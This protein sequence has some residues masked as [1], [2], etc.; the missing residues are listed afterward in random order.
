MALWTDLPRT[1]DKVVILGWAETTRNLAPWDDDYEIW[2]LNEA[3]QFS[4]IKRMDRL[5]QLHPRWDFS[6]SNNVNDPNHLH[7]LR[8]ESGKCAYC[9]GKGFIEI[10]EKG[11]DKEQ[12]AC[13]FCDGGIYTPKNRPDIPIYMQK[14]HADIPGSVAYPLKEVAD[15]LFPENRHPYFTSSFAYMAG[16]AYIMGYKEIH[17]YGFEMGTE[18]EYHYQRANAEYIIGLIQAKGVKVVVPKQSPLLD[19]LLYGYENMRTGY[20]QQLE[21]RKLNLERQFEKAKNMTTFAEGEA[22][23]IRSL[24]VDNP[25]EADL[26][27]LVAIKEH[28]ANR[29]QALAG[30]IH[31]ALTEA[32]NLMSLYDKYF[33]VG[34]EQGDEEAVDAYAENQKFVNMVYQSED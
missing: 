17:V 16:L 28:A 6:R 13:K 32:Q 9:L 15:A 26:Q 25:D 10:Q 4:W 34:T 33:I 7:W 19:G 31:G 24:A 21:M 22:N 14:I 11:K 29:K 23:A 2:T 5:F 8:N 3:Y 20:R 30:F 12:R 27:K 18:T 1:K